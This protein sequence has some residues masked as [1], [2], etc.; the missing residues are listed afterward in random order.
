MFVRNAIGFL[1]ISLAVIFLGGTVLGLAGCDSV[2]EAIVKV[3]N[4][5]NHSVLDIQEQSNRS[6]IVNAFTGLAQELD[7]HCYTPHDF[8]TKVAKMSEIDI[9]RNGLPN[10]SAILECGPA[11]YNTLSLYKNKRGYEVVFSQMNPGWSVPP[12]FCITQER[13]FAYFSARFPR[14]SLTLLLHP[15]NPCG[16]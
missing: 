8:A 7:Y 12:Y 4:S 9:K 6:T 14:E 15:N 5:A 2:H 13:I 3:D 11:W 10:K 1:P 16:D